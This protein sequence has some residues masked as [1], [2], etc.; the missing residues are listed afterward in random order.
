[1][2]G[3][4]R[5][6]A[7]AAESYRTMRIRARPQI[8]PEVP[9]DIVQSAL[10]ESIKLKGLS[11]KDAYPGTTKTEALRTQSGAEADAMVKGMDKNAL[12]LHPMTAN[13]PILDEVR[14]LRNSLKS[15]A[16]AL[17]D[18]AKIADLINKF[19]S[20]RQTSAGPRGSG[21]RILTAS[22][23]NEIKQTAQR[24]AKDLYARR[25]AGT[26]D[27]ASALN[28]R[29]NEALASGAQKLLETEHD[30]LATML[31]RPTGDLA[32]A[33]A[34]TGRMIRLNE[35][36]RRREM[37]PPLTPQM[38]SLWGDVRGVVDNPAVR[39]R[40]ALAVNSP[41]ARAIATQSPRTLDYLLRALFAAQPQGGR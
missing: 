3:A 32:G 26:L 12:S 18:R 7:K 38:H 8:A 34:R 30:R 36:V 35:V 4:L 41:A 11:G 2:A 25:D 24:K 40:A 16:D 27:D 15:S 22:E 39:S 14:K 1:M 19:Q 23:V 20:S 9:A 6:P 13:G 37:A 29:F 21:P 10:D 33:N 28:L 17:G 31:G 5:V